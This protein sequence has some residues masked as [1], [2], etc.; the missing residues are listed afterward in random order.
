[1]K[2]LCNINGVSVHCAVI[3]NSW[4]NGMEEGGCFLL[5]FVGYKIH[6]PLSNRFCFL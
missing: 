2:E 6:I 4:S 5:L 3:W 1:M